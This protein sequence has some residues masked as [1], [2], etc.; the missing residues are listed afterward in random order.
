M[1][2]SIACM[3]A[4]VIVGSINITGLGLKISGLITAA[5]GGRI[6]IM[7]ILTAIVC[8]V[9]GMG[10]PTSAC[11]IV[12]AVL[13]APAMIDLGVATISAHMFVLY[14]G[15]VAAITPPVALAVF[16]AVGISGGDMWKTGLQAMK[17][18]ISGF[19]IPFIF[20]YNTDLLM[21]NSAARCV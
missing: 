8:I 19:V 7:G 12:L 13:V 3:I 9:L 10:L 18:A 16:A 11:Y 4:G 6:F 21:F 1:A 14:Y 5:A 2:V 15:V 17:M 20:L